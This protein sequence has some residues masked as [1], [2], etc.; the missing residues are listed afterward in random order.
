MVEFA[1]I[2]WMVAYL[3]IY[4]TTKCKRKTNDP[5]ECIIKKNN[6]K[7][8]FLI[9]RLRVDQSLAHTLNRLAF[10]HVGI[11]FANN[12][13]VCCHFFFRFITVFMTRC[14]HIQLSVFG[15][16]TLWPNCNSM[17]ANHQTK[18]MRPSISYSHTIFMSKQ[19]FW[20]YLV[21]LWWLKVIS[22]RGLW[23]KF[24]CCRRWKKKDMWHVTVWRL[25]CPLVHRCNYFGA[26]QM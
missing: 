16:Q 2:R 22:Y 15:A 23:W 1:V 18:W 25:R 3:P 13:N 20:K 14:K 5:N 9:K 7:T 10:V 21:L 17:T 4:K 19:Y 24:C 26:Q 6:K 11:A 8:C 12:G